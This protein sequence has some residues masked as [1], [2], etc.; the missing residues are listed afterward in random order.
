MQFLQVLVGDQP[1]GNAL[2]VPET[3]VISTPQ[4]KLKKKQKFNECV[5][6]TA[7]PSP[8]KQ[9]KMPLPRSI[10]KREE[11]PITLVAPV[12]TKHTAAEKLP[13]TQPEKHPVET[14]KSKTDTICTTQTFA[15]KVAA[16]KKEK[17]VV[18]MLTEI[19]QSKKEPVILI[20]TQA[21]SAHG[22]KKQIP[23]THNISYS[24]A[25]R[26]A[27]SVPR[28][29]PQLSHQPIP[30]HVISITAKPVPLTK[31][32]AVP[33]GKEVE[34]VSTVPKA[35]ISPPQV[36]LP[37]SKQTTERSAQPI[38]PT[39]PRSPSPPFKTILNV[40]SAQPV[41]GTKPRSPSPPFE[42]VLKQR[43]ATNKGSTSID[44]RFLVA[45]TNGYS[46]CFTQVLS[47]R[48][49][50]RPAALVAHWLYFRC[51]RGSGSITCKIFS[52]DRVDS[53]SYCCL[54]R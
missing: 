46:I 48:K 53:G 34:V 47:F 51:E 45:V 43:G 17:N 29:I 54:A 39:K 31:K 5:A 30:Q 11:H 35:S 16:R 27:N 37:T 25:V 49:A 10:G 21:I 23:T 44:T 50:G 9:K 8:S 20:Q 3:N 26:N 40:Q 36:A 28:T 22:P 2:G 12:D 4:K 14:P 32:P 33:T 38:S 6:I 42:T 7:E 41:L 24:A 15:Q 13:N 19:D 1:M 18:D 52:V